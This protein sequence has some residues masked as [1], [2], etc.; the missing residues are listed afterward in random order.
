MK[1]YD[2]RLP[3]HETPEDE[4]TIHETI[5]KLDEMLT[6]YGID[7]YFALPS[8]AEIEA[9]PKPLVYQL[10]Y[11]SEQDVE[12]TLVVSLWCKLYLNKDKQHILEAIV[13]RFGK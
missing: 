10:F 11:Q 1:L 6:Q 3:I 7:H 9:D 13:K 8:E 12:L 4:P 5:E 2:V